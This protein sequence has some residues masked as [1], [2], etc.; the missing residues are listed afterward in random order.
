VTHDPAVETADSAAR[1]ARFDALWM[2]RLDRILPVPTVVL[3]AVV[4]WTAASPW[5]ALAA[6]VA[7][8]V[9]NVA[10]SQFA[11]RHPLRPDHPLRLLASMVPIALL[12]W[13][14]GPDGHGWILGVL[15]AAMAVFARDRWGM[16]R[17]ALLFNGAAVAA[18]WA[19]GGGWTQ[20]V[21][22]AVVLCAVSWVTVGLYETM[23]GVWLRAEA[24]REALEASNERLTHALQARQRFLATMSHEVRTPMNGILGTAQLLERT[25]LQPQQQ[26]LVRVIGESGQG[27][28]HILD[29]ILDTAR[30]DADAVELE[31]IPFDPAALA[32][33]VVDLLRPT[34]HADVSLEVSCSD[35]PDQ[36]LG[37]PN[38]LRQVLLNLAG[39]AV[40]FT[41]Q[42]QV[43]VGLSWAGDHLQVEVRDTGIGI[44]EH[45]QQDLFDPFVQAEQGTA[46]RFGGT[47][48]GLTISHRLVDLMG[49]RLQVSSTLGEGSRFH[50]RIPAAAHTRVEPVDAH[51]TE[52]VPLSARIL[53]VDDNAVNRMVAERMLEG[54]G[55]DV[56]TL[57]DGAPVL[58]TV[59]THDFDLVLMDCRM[60]DVDGLEATRR[61]RRSGRTLPVIALTAGVTEAERTACLE[62][63][64]DDVLT[65]PVHVD[66]LR[67][68]V[69]QW[70]ARGERS[71]AG[72]VDASTPQPAVS[73]TRTATSGSRR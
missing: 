69:Q 7:Y 42:G 39:N 30:L 17:T 11:L 3:G 46:R 72:P 32:R 62:A 33:G 40:K 73:S 56:T 41:E 71:G 9:A 8:V 23:L 59:R 51:P 19:V 63:G 31:S 49:G 34:V 52:P 70:G 53:L 68:S 1:V 67:R 64:M 20:V 22:S 36:L 66:D 21:L 28:L 57:C 4:V 55:C 61:L 29:D 47:G 18:T 6:V 5:G 44:S 54:L 13:A 14:C 37:D 25:E 15:P 26:D 58:D 38:R 12:V 35:L 2:K 48:L 27:L 16:A 10:V 45:A 60:V 43:R 65:K 24:H 50:F